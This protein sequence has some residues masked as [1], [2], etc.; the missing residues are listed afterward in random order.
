MEGFDKG[1]LYIAEDD[2]ISR[3]VKAIKLLDGDLHITEVGRRRPG[4]IYLQFSYETSADVSS[5]KMNS[6]QTHNSGWGGVLVGIVGR[7]GGVVAG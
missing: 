1:V 3:L 2:F 5:T 7:G 6:F 4:G